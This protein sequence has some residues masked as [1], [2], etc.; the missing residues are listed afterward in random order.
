MKVVTDVTMQCE[1]SLYS[2][3]HYHVV[4]LSPYMLRVRSMKSPINSS[5]VATKDSKT[6]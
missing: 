1:M 6:R 5:P 4:T 3:I 2:D